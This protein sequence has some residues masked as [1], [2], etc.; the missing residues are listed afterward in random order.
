MTTRRMGPIQG[1]GGEV[2]G[3]VN[4]GGGLTILQLPRDSGPKGRR[5]AGGRVLE[6][7]VSCT[8][9]GEGDTEKTSGRGE[10]TESTA[11]P[12]VIGEPQ[13]RPPQAR[14]HL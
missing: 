1:K 9:E 7:A 8:L 10:W 11:S 12:R 14:Q 3:D 4:L 5:R 13:G 6:A 2:G